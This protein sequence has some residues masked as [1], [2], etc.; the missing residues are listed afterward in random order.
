MKRIISLLFALLVSNT[1]AIDKIWDMR[2]TFGPD[3]RVS[4][5]FGF[6]VGL[7]SEFNSNILFPINF[8]SRLSREFEIGAKLDIQTYNKMDNTEAFIDL[9]FRYR[10]KS[11]TFVELDGYLGLNHD[12]EGALVF[13]FGTQQYISK[14][15]ANYYEARAGVFD[16]V[17]GEDGYVKFSFGMTPTIIFG[18]VMRTMLEVTSSGSVGHLRDDFMIDIIPK[19]ELIFGSTRIRVD[20]DIGVMQ[21]KNNDRK[22]IALYV[23]TTL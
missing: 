21:E 22:T 8:S 14:N 23:M 3:S 7:R 20:F 10:L 18:D 17:T 5:K 2:Y 16:G 13:T 4:P 9:G 12:N 11:W 19:I 6:G 15:F 1:F